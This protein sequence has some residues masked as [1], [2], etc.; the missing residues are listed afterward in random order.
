MGDGAQKEYTIWVWAKQKVRK[1]ILKKGRGGR[2]GGA[3]PIC[4]QHRNRNL[5]CTQ[6]CSTNYP[7]IYYSSVKIFQFWLTNAVYLLVRVSM[8]QYMGVLILLD[9]L[10]K[11]YKQK[12]NICV[13]FQ[14]NYVHNGHRINNPELTRVFILI[15]TSE[16]WYL[17][18]A[19]V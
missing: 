2:G 15:C 9:N 14:N 12:L 16:L 10:N 18:M 8:D 1:C 19:I 11:S 13:F 7:V 4:I 17:I 6:V 5:I 3:S